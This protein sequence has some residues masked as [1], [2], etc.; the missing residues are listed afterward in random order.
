[1]VVISLVAAFVADGYLAFYAVL[2]VPLLY[3]LLAGTNPLSVTLLPHRI[4]NPRQT[5]GIF[6]R[7]GDRASIHEDGK[8]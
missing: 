4:L 6:F 2:F 7:M 8:L 3:P 1:L 5:A